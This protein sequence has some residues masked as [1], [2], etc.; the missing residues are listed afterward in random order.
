M[1]YLVTS[2]F[3]YDDWVGSFYPVGIL[4]WEWLTHYMLELNTCEGN[5][6]FYALPRP[7]SFKAMDGEMG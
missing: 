2:D 4:K 5:S 7:Y 3:N 6:I 1:V